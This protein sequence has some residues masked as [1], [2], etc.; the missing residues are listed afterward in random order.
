MFLQRELR[1]K[2]SRL[3]EIGDVNLPGLLICIFLNAIHLP[4]DESA[5]QLQI[6]DVYFPISYLL[7][8][9]ICTFSTSIYSL[10]GGD[11]A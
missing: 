1:V 6:P 5:R 4:L 11:T 8:I 7:T 10:E 2:H 9:T 3:R